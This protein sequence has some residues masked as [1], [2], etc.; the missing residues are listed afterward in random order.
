MKYALGS[1]Q[2]KAIDRYT[3]ET[4][5]IPSMVLMEKAAMAVVRHTKE[6]CSEKD[7]ILAVCGY[8]NNGGDGIAAARILFMEGYSV[9]IY[10][11]GDRSHAT[12]ET[13]QQLKIARKLGIQVIRKVK[14]EEYT[15]IIDAIFGIG[16]TRTVTGEFRK[17]VEQINQAKNW[18]VS[19][20][21][22]S[23]VSADDGKVLGIAVNADLTVTFGYQKIGCLLFPGSEYTGKVYVEDIGFANGG[24]TEPPTRFYFDEAPK[25]LL[26]VRKKN[27]NKGTYGKVLV[28]AG[29]KNMS[30]AAYF[31]A[32][33]AYRMGSGLVRILTANE[34]REILQRQIPE[35]ILTTYETREDGISE[36]D[37]ESIREAVAWASVIVLGPGLSMSAM[38]ARIVNYVIC[39]C[40]VPLIIDADGLN[41][42]SRLISEKVPAEDGVE[43]RI[44]YLAKLLPAGTILTPHKKELSVL[45]GI[46]LADLVGCLI[47][48]SAPCTYNNE[49]IYVKKDVRTIVSFGNSDYINVSGND[50]MAT[51]GSGDVLA[52]MIAGLLAQGESPKMAAMAGCFLHGLAGD[53]AA[54]NKGTHSMLASDILEAIPQV[55]KDA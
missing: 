19:V 10:M 9:A 20:D 1:G 31:A 45:T 53:E 24:L 5:G 32:T 28:I 12:R 54:K 42:I 3:I 8:G 49:L 35:A 14:W 36:T 48:S 27:S 50:G 51:A 38:S 55:L 44:R 52:G 43:G 2:M 39:E 13:K 30:G 22:P 29:S 7:N 4:I 47:D 40:K 17:V 6:L 16:L 46:P 23:G 18:V 37:A 11:V 41:I 25:A 33:A 26:P 34:N 21:I 15:G